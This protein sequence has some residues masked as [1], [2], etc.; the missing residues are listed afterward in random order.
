METG[1]WKLET[2]NQR[3]ET[4]NRKL[5]TVPQHSFK[6][7]VSSFKFQVFILLFFVLTLYHLSF[8]FV[9]QLYFQRACSYFR[10]GDYG[11]AASQLKKAEKYQPNDYIIKKKSGKVYLK[12]GQLNA[13]AKSSF[14]LT[15]KAKEYYA[16][17]F[18]LNP[19]DAEAVYGL[20]TADAR[21]EELYHSLHPGKKDSPYS[22]LPYFKKAV[23]LRPNGILY[24]YELARFLHKKEK[25]KELPSVIHKLAYIYPR[26]YYYLKKEDF[27]SDSVKTAYLRGLMK[28]AREKIS[29][30]ET[31][32]ILSLMM[33][34]EKQW[35]SAL[36]HYEKAIKHKSFRNISGNYI[37]LGSLYL[38]NRQFEKAKTSFVQAL[39]MSRSRQRDSERIYIIYKNEGF[40]EEV[41]QFYQQAHP[42][43]LSSKAKIMT[44]RC[45]IDMKQYEQARQILIKLN[46]R[47][48]AAAA[49][50]WLAR[51]AEAEKDW[52]SMELAIQKATVLD[53]ENRH[54]HNKFSYV[55][56][57]QKKFERAEKEAALASKPKSQITNYK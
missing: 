3:L 9:S 42:V 30:R 21:L 37:R 38:K 33:A 1:N 10:K 34:E 14:L 19:L 47:E 25:S 39:N 56:R 15:K 40:L 2:G 55:L 29:P 53:P 51:I 52:D 57:R 24:N 23:Q 32:T 48:P 43:I 36:S 54:Y 5:E 26:T 16:E 41:C 46:R 4:G 13:K 7:Q 50:Y 17:A 22:P 44:A 12:L 6:F 28:A 8:R 31:H 49:Y 20:A 18:R 45:L 35:P 11:L 27:W